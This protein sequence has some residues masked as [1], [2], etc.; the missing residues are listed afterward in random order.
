MRP[1]GCVGVGVGWCDILCAM[2]DASKSTRL[3][4]RCA[5]CV[6]VCTCVCKCVYVFTSGARRY[7]PYRR[8]TLQ[9]PR[10][11][12]NPPHTRSMLSHTR[13]RTYQSNIQSYTSVAHISHT[14]PPPPHQEGQHGPQCP[15]QAHVAAD[16]E[17]HTAAGRHR[18]ALDEE[19]CVAVAGWEGEGG[20]GVEKGEGREDVGR[21]W[22]GGQRE[23]RGCADEGGRALP[24]SWVS[25]IR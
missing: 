12:T 2:V 6:C 9:N 22:G 11:Q 23:E 19:A 3:A 4:Q 18:Q 5:V 24:Y 16:A 1:L 7:I 20:G 15:G 13:C 25:Y 17:H 14:P 21:A 8:H 10:T